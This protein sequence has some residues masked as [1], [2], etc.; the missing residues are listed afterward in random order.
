MEGSV[1]SALRAG[2]GH[3]VLTLFWFV[4][5]VAAVPVDDVEECESHPKYQ[6]YVKGL[7]AWSESRRATAERLVAFDKEAGE[8]R[9]RLIEWLSSIETIS[10]EYTA[11]VFTDYPPDL[12]ST[13]N[14][15][16]IR[17]TYRSRGKYPDRAVFM[18]TPPLQGSGGLVRAVE[19]AILNGRFVTKY[20]TYGA[21]GELEDVSVV[22]EKEEGQ[23]PSGRALISPDYL[24][25]AGTIS[26]P[27]MQ[28]M[29]PLE[30]LLRMGRTRLLRENGTRV[31]F[32]TLAPFTNFILQIYLDDSG[33]PK[34][35][36]IGFGTSLTFEELTSLGRDP[37][38][39]FREAMDLDIRN[40]TVVNGVPFPLEISAFRY[41]TVETNLPLLAELHYP[42]CKPI[43][44]GVAPTF[45]EYEL[46]RFD[47]VGA[48]TTRAL[49][50]R[51]YMRIDPATLRINEPLPDALFT[52]NI[53]EGARYLRG[54]GYTE[55]EMEEEINPPWYRRHTMAVIAGAAL[56]ILLIIAF[57]VYFCYDRYF[58]KA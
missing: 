49:M 26:V 13:E 15:P 34:E 9:D 20:E 55:E 10:C 19:G 48:A 56:L 6:E 11:E 22:L 50:G 32:H 44:E 52:V 47:R 51:Q 43:V 4:Q 23:N 25:L 21:S 14:A 57:A 16:P 39:V 36:Q 2:I 24:L 7:F 30:E 5:A 58:A 8:L 18:S 17:V 29:A 53:P 3:C 40:Y 38:K 45:E 1:V 28:R 42:W 27:G 46:S 35:I 37:T 12:S 41:H 31:L 54:P 33:L